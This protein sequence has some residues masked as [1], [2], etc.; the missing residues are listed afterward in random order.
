M[1]EEVY[2]FPLS[3]AQQRLW[4][5]DQMSPANPFYNINAAVPFQWPVNAA[6]LERALNEIVRRH[7][8]LRTTF[9]VAES[10]PAQ[11]VH[12]D[13][14]LALPVVDL[15]G[16][17]KADQ[18]AETIRLATEE[19]RMPFD[20]TKGPL[21]RATLLRLGEHES[22]FL[23]AMHHIISDGWSMGIFFQEL[24]EIYN[25]LALGRP[26]ALPE[27]P[28]QYAD[29]AVW[30]RDWLQGEVLAEQLAYWKRQ[31]RDLPVLQLPADYPRPA[32]TT[33]QGALHNVVFSKSLSAQIQAFSQKEGVTLFMFLLAAFAALLHRYTGQDDLVVGAPI[34]NRNRAEIERLIGFF[35]NSLVMRADLSGNPTFRELLRRVRG[36]ALEA[37]AHQDLPFEK[38]VEELQPE[39]DLSRNPLFQ[40][41]FQ[42][43]NPPTW[44][45]NA[46]GQSA[47]LVEVQRGTAILDLALS[48]WES[49]EG[50]L[51]VIEYS[52]DLF[53]PATIQHMVEHFRALLEGIAAD[54]E[55]RLSEL[56]LLGEAERRQLLV[57][58]N[59]THRA[60]PRGA[61]LHQL[62]EAQAAASPQATAV[63]YAGE[64]LRYQE[65]D[66]RANQ[67]AHFLRG[68]GVGADD[69]V[70]ICMERS[71]EMV[72]ALL[73]VLKA[74]GAYVPL[75]PAYPKERLAYIVDD[76]RMK[77]I[78]TTERLKGLLP[79]SGARLV[80]LETDW[81]R[82]SSQP[83]EKPVELVAADNLAYII[84][85]SG[86]TGQPKGVM[87]THRAIC[88]H[89]LWMNERFPLTGDDRVIQRTPY[90]F[91]ASVWEFYAPLLAGAQLVVAPAESH[92]NV[93]DLAA[94]IGEERIT[95]LQLVPSLLQVYLD[96]PGIERSTALKRVF[97]GGEPLPAELQER[98]FHHFDPLETSLYN[99]YGPTEV[100]IDATFAQCQNG[101]GRK[102]VPI[103]RPVSN[104]EVYILDRYLNP[105][106]VG[107]PGELYLGGES[108]SRGYLHRPGLTA[109]RFIPH[110]FSRQPGAR[111]YRTGDL[112][113]YLPDGNI[114]YLSRVDHQV[115]LRGYRIE[116]GEI[117]ATLRQHP[118][119]QETVIQVREDQP[120]DKR[121]VAYVVQ[122]PGYPGADEAF[123]ERDWEAEKVG[124]WQTV[125][126]ETYRE[127]PALAD[128]TFNIT[129]WNSSYTGE[130][131]PAEEMREWLDHT[132]ER[133][134]ANRPRRVLEI[135]CGSGLI[136]FRVAPHCAEYWGT[137]F[138]AAAMEH[139]RELVSQPG[140]ALPQVNL[141]VRAADNFAGIVRQS[142]D[143][144]ILN[145]VVQYFPSSGYLTRVL[146]AAVQAVAPGGVIFIGDVRNLNLLEAFHTSVELYRASDGLPLEQLRQRVHKQMVQEK[147]LVIDPAFFTALQ[148]DWPRITHVQ[149][150]PKR[151]SYAN[152]LSLFRYDV[153][154][155]V[156]AE[157]VA[158]AEEADNGQATWVDWAKEG[159][160]LDRLRRLLSDT[161]P[162]QFG[163][164]QAPNAR[165]LAYSRAQE[166]LNQDSD[167]KT[168]GALRKYVQGFEA[169]GVDPEAVWLLGETLPYSVTLSWANAARDGSFDALFRH[170][171]LATG[172]G[173]RPSAVEKPLRRARHRYTNNPL[174]GLFAQMLV[175]RL[176]EFLQEK[177]PEYMVPQNFILLDAL[178]RLPNG[179]MNHRALPPVDVLRPFEAGAYVAPRTPVEEM[180]EAIW[181]EVLTLDRIGIHD[182]FFSDLGG[183]SLLA[184]QIIS[185]VREA[186]QIE[187]PL[188][189]IFEEPTIAG[190]GQ[191]ILTQMVGAA[192]S[193]QLARAL[194]AIDQ[195]SDEE[196][197]RLLA[198]EKN[199][200]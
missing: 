84:Y 1:A 183:H 174:Q 124:Q 128:P 110:P 192:D 189:R 131:I 141:L 55:R 197:Q 83:P 92:K 112:V 4:F 107:V 37:Y 108:L 181:A 41:T 137:D 85:T 122:D 42:M 70:G 119:V 171:R 95:T 176:R 142:F 80:C 146:E 62:F 199:D 170:T 52:T 106:P 33:Y 186:F 151:G 158:D 148:E 185:R 147:E 121:L 54:P 104:V 32:V 5:L 77:V 14:A 51:G 12:S 184:T 58:W 20:L 87:I 136:L 27:L 61:R 46:A 59:N 164:C 79:E 64:A 25:A 102:F 74:G 98:F 66:R 126:E 43:I 71:L 114:E 149:V 163:V 39:R 172:N 63:V 48:L 47:P 143:L 65:L 11:L 187:L 44:R 40:V 93:T 7:E 135:G 78:L 125:Y 89:M 200:G 169:E 157:A 6:L 18:E 117:E 35:V 161:A 68:L 160:S 97:C 144:V 72:A 140:T 156:D 50:I 193:E 195:L 94:L 3:F 118:G 182:N 196:V 8:A 190:L 175:P 75:D 165:V 105:V 56:P 91:D 154:L 76:A 198:E 179:K 60:Y 155:H 109:E 45:K 100:T 188:Q 167:L 36:V 21:I 73:G 2:E 99:L 26:P 153:L 22:L 132:V 103:G 29:F 81:Q 134:L 173:T 139:L 129:G 113:R 168:A 194:E 180:L 133:I 31:L 177:L 69:L 166:K 162:G 127:R 30:Q 9:T 191:A 159:L 86:S 96:Q 17:P 24:T 16:L 34:A 23:L 19:A 130:P 38:L 178:P 88:N 28:I 13:L 49:S 120:G 115:K 57:A 111:L 90:N 116:L 138:S 15:R 152:E 145:S 150:L 101:S 10:E 123:R 82:I 53:A 67:A